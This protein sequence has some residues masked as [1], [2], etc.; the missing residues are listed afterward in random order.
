MIRWLKVVAMSVLMLSLPL[1][2]VHGLTMPSCG[3]ADAEHAAGA[4]EHQHDIA[5]QHD[6]DIA[7][8]AHQD[9]A[10]DINLVCDGCSNCQAC[11]APAVA[12]AVIDMLSDAVDVFPLALTSHIPLF[13]PE[14]L[15]RPPLQS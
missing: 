4:G 14:Q 2:S 12:S 3:D 6:T 8:D 10:A 11:S 15:Q 1:Q 7:A 9:M 13:D 5:H